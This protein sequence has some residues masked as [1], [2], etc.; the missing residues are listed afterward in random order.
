[1]DILALRNV[2]KHFGG[3]AAV[4][5]VNCSVRQG[6]IFGLIG[7]NGAGKTTL[8]NVICGLADPYQGE[9]TFKDQ[10]IAGKKPWDIARLGIG[11]TFQIVQ[12][13]HGLT[14]REN[15]AIGAMFGKKGHEG[16]IKEALSLAD[17]ALELTG[18]SHRADDLAT[19]ITLSQ[20]KRLEMARALAMEPDL[21]LL[22]EVMAGLHL[23]EISEM[24][25]IVK[26]VNEQGITIFVI[27]HVMKAVMGISH[28][29]MV[30]HYG[31]TIAVDTPERI[32]ENSRVIE[33]Y[34]GERYAARRAKRLAGSEMGS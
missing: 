13:F 5:G 19:Q 6:E 30:L 18:L 31:K 3:V 21:L 22:D 14:I 2:S 17:K 32:A 4:D 20:R 11:R 24:M 16:S 23:T 33:V 29:I 10:R 7:P 25:E 34:L 26:R 28:R 9:I 1:M 27:E 8:L 15:V 12:P